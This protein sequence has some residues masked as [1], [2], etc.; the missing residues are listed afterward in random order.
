M[1]HHAAVEILVHLAECVWGCLPFARDDNADVGDGEGGVGLA[2]SGPAVG[3]VDA[4]G[5]IAADVG[6]ASRG[7]GLDE[8]TALLQP[9]LPFIQHSVEGRGGHGVSEQTSGSVKDHVEKE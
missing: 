5:G 2:L 1:S 9:F 6:W 7:G 3:D 4:L 8:M